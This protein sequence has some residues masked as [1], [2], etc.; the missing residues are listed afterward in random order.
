MEK[1]KNVGKREKNVFFNFNKQQ[2]F[3]PKNFGN[4]NNPNPN[5]NF[6]LFWK[7]LIFFRF[8]TLKKEKNKNK[9]KNFLIQCENKNILVK[10]YVILRIF[11]CNKFVNKI[12]KKV[13][14]FFKK[15]YLF[16]LL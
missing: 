13:F 11:V 4:F 10:F 3:L 9:F 16:L 7:K 2:G 5:V 12:E 6:K 14:F 8:L 1:E 15:C